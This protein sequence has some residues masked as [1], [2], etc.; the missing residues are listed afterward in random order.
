MDRPTMP[1]GITLERRE[2]RTTRI[3]I[4]ATASS[5]GTGELFVASE[6][7]REFLG[8]LLATPAAEMDPERQAEE[9]GL[10]LSLVQW[11][12]DPGFVRWFR[13]HLDASAELDLAVLVRKTIAAAVG[14]DVKALQMV[15]KL[16][17][18]RQVVAP[19]NVE[20][21]TEEVWAALAA[22]EAPQL[23]EGDGAPGS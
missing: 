14:G 19:G 8:A 18:G 12:Q 5:N 15:P 13:S 16:V 23:E 9:M 21:S 3:G 1:A 20:V 6:A 17:A 10:E 22:G 7:Q 4:P 11:R 2:T